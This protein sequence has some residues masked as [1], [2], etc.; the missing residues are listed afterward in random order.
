M[1]PD[2]SSSPQLIILIV[3]Y[4]LMSVGIVGEMRSPC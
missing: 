1:M 3:G 4:R 2:E